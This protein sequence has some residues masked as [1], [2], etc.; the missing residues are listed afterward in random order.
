MPN[1]MNVDNFKANFDG[2]SRPNRY[3]ISGVIGSNKL[4]TV[5]AE[6]S[7]LLVRATSMP[8]VTVGIMR[9]PFRGR[10]VKIP[11][12]RTYEEW[13]CTFYDSFS[14]DALYNNFWNWNN[15]FN[16]HAS[17]TPAGGAIEGFGI[18]LDPG[19]NI[20]QDWTVNQL[21]MHGDVGRCVVM[22]NCWP[23]VVS[24]IALSYDSADTIAEF[25]VT[26]AY[27]YLKTDC[28]LSK[29]DA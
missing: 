18:N 6:T 22:A 12:D 2:G 1:T 24:E 7:G 14:G 16:D 21:S 20:Y 23:T 29:V 13:T 11:G 26:F 8:A 28:V 3:S 10:V 5:G 27:D 19:A 15:D 25:T 4:Q 9:V 17:N